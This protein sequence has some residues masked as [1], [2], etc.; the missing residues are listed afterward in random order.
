MEAVMES[1]GAVETLLTRVRDW[2]RRRNELGGLDDE[3]LRRVAAELG[4]ST[5]TLEDLAK[6]GPDAAHNLYERMRALGLSKADVEAAA[7][8]VLRDLQRTCAC[9]NEKRVCERDLA[10]R[11]ADPVWRSYCPNAVT[12]EALAKLKAHASV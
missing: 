4:M 6:R 7:H 11:P 1:H 8:G 12:L 9:C 2:W 10:E 5:N 3:E